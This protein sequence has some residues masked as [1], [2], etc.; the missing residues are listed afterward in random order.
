MT[1]EEFAALKEGD[2]V[3]GKS[4]GM[5]YVVTGNYGSHV[6]AV[7]TVDM[8]NPD[9]FDLVQKAAKSEIKTSIVPDTGGKE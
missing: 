2:I 3:R 7:R 6:V 9:E 1:N 5:A 4:S 8:T